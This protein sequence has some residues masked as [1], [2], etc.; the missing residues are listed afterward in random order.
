[1]FLMPFQPHANR[2]V[3]AP[4]KFL[5]YPESNIPPASENTQGPGGY[6]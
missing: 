6:N 4:P 3:G 2:M 1:M 5:C